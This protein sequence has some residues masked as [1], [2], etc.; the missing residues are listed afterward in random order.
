MEQQNDLL[1]LCRLNMMGEHIADSP[2]P[3]K[4]TALTAIDW[5]RRQIAA[6]IQS[7]ALDPEKPRDTRG[8]AARGKSKTQRKAVSDG[9]T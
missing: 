8:D 2:A 3:D 6:R 5:K 7:A 1:D 4:D 9:Q